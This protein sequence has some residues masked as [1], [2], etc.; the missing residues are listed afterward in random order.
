M[1]I[2]QT[3]ASPWWSYC[4][5]LKP[6]QSLLILFALIERMKEILPGTNACDFP[7]YRIISLVMLAKTARGVEIIVKC[8][9][10]LHALYCTSK[11][12]TPATF[13]MN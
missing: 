5:F 3:Y 10:E 6:L 13:Y 9:S 8:K 7:P 2:E 1:G 12:F 4:H 11:D